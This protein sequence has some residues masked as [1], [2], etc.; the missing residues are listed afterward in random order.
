VPARV[1][2]PI[3]RTAG[4]TSPGLQEKQGLRVRSDR[5]LRVRPV[6]SRPAACTTSSGATSSAPPRVV[7]AAR[8]IPGLT[9]PMRRRVV[10]GGG[11][12]R[13]SHC[14]C[15]TVLDHLQRKTVSRGSVMTA[16]T[17]PTGPLDSTRILL[18]QTP[19]TWRQATQGWAVLGTA[20]TFAAA[21]LTCFWVARRFRASD[22]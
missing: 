2:K 22:R 8:R 9:Q 15:S 17:A 6:H 3:P 14:P 21:A 4:P 1:R 12:E 19:V 18:T 5:R 13:L 11:S 16:P 20:G 10:P 7:L